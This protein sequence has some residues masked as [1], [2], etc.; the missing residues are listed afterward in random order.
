MLPD[1]IIA[2]LNSE[3]QCREYQVQQL[4]ALYAVGLQALSFVTNPLTPPG[5]SPI[6]IDS[7]HPR[8]HSNRQNLDHSILLPSL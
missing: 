1:E 5:A 6:N 2:Q 8:P 7:Q 3:F 4:T